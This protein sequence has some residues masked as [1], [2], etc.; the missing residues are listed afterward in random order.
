MRTF[1]SDNSELAYYW[2]LIEKA[3]DEIKI[4]LINL[5]SESIVNKSSFNEIDYN[6]EEKK[7]EILKKCCGGWSGS[8]SP[9]EIISTIKSDLSCKEPPEFD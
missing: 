9:E 7:K 2:S 4:R 3:G 5:L 1:I 8:E 6:M